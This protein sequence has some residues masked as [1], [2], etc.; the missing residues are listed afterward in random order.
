MDGWIRLYRKIQKHWIWRIREPYDKRSAWIDLILM[1]N[2]K[3]EIIEFDNSVIEVER[4]QRITSL[5]KL[6]DRW[7]WSRHKVSNFLNRLEKERHVGTGEGQ[8]KNS[9]K[10]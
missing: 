2:H 3:K 5:E 4:G 10:Y 6:A 8:Q 9:Y 7:M 1:V